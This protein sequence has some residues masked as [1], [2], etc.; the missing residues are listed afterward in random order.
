M[1]MTMR[2]HKDLFEGTSS[3]ERLLCYLI[4]Q[5]WVGRWIMGISISHLVFT[6]IVFPTQVT[7]IFTRGFFDTGVANAEVGNTVWFFFFGIP[8]FIVGYMI[9]RDEKKTVM[10]PFQEVILVSL[11]CM[12]ALGILLIPASGFWL[13]T[14]AIF[15]FYLKN[16]SANDNWN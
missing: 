11:V 2:G 13:M 3:H 15:G 5:R 6:F 4:K 9:D 1:P 7:Y 10:P 8:L 14:P 12:T 16:K